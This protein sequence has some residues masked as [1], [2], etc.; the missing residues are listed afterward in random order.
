MPGA[1][2]G[3][4]WDLLGHPRTL[5]TGTLCPVQPSG[6][7]WELLGHPRT[8]RTGTLCLVQPSR[9]PWNLPGHPRI[10]RTGTCPV[11]PLGVQD[12]PGPSRM[13]YAILDRQDYPWQSWT[14]LSHQTTIK[15]LSNFNGTC[16]ITSHQTAIKLQWYPCE[17][18]GS[19]GMSWT[20]WTWY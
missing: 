1:A 17:F 4:S 15:L 19:S 9:M 10:H 5:R 6:M 8:L 3:M 11:Q 2:S 18:P 14:T 13:A 7:S 20:F 16:S 12:I